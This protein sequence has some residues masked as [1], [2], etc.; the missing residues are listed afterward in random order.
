MI[1]AV[2]LKCALY[3]TELA[4]VIVA[5]PVYVNERCYLQQIWFAFFSTADGITVPDKIRYEQ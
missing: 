3:K 5:L 2:I 1:R 4:F